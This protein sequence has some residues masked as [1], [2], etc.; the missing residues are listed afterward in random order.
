MH[1]E[2][3][4]LYTV[5]YYIYK[6]TLVCSISRPGL[7]QA[8][9]QAKVWGSGPGLWLGSGPWALGSGLWALSSLFFFLSPFSK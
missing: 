1:I 5:Y 6:K 3:Y 7:G 2:Y 4:T 9:A 8:L